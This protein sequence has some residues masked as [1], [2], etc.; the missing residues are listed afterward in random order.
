VALPLFLEGP[1]RLMKLLEG[2]R[3]KSLHRQLRTA[4]YLTNLGMYKVNVSLDDQPHEIGRARAFTPGW[5]ENE[6]IWLHMAFK[7]LL[8]LLNAGLYDEFFDA[9]QHHLP[10]FMDAEVY[11]RSPL[12]IALSSSAAPTRMPP[13]TGRDL[14]PV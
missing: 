7:Y 14:L 5:L 10:A 3:L 9:L 2:G 12:R 8:E 4:H 6:S 13:F 1:V 11:G